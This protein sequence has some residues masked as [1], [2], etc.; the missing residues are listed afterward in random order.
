MHRPFVINPVEQGGKR[1]GLAGAGGAGKSTKPFSSLR[2]FVE[3]P[4]GNC[5]PLNGRDLGLQLSQD[6]GEIA[7]LGEDVDPEAGSVAEGE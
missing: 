7:F 5:I 2:H 1:G 6:G 4:R 3:R